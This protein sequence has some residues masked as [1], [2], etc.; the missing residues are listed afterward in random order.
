MDDLF[1]DLHGFE[2]AE[3][4]KGKEA[5]FNDGL[6]IGLLQGREL[7]AQKG[8]ELGV[9]AGFYQ[10]FC[11][12]W[13]QLKAVDPDA[14]PEKAEKAVTTLEEALTALIPVLKHPR[15]PRQVT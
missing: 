15:D 12:Q 6:A 13:R 5:G 1:E 3:I 9:E 4:D 11:S 10:G 7:G 14:I 8:Y 2:D